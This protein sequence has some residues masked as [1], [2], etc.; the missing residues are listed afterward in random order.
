[1]DSEEEF[2]NCD[3]CRSPQSNSLGPSRPNSF[4]CNN[5]TSAVEKN[6]DDGA[7]VLLPQTHNVRRS[8]SGVFRNIEDQDFL[9][10]NNI[11]QDVLYDDASIFHED[12]DPFNGCV[13]ITETI[14]V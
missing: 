4:N 3:S 10:T 8:A 12:V 9:E 5:P 14:L 6:E 2:S 7:G 1:M 13:F 11:T